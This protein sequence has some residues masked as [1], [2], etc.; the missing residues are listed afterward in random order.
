MYVSADVMQELDILQNKIDCAVN[1]LLHIHD[2]LQTGSYVAEDYAPGVFF[3]YCEMY[4]YS[5]TLR[6]YVDQIFEQARGERLKEGEAMSKESD[7]LPE[8]FIEMIRTDPEARKT[9]EEFVH[10]IAAERVV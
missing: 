9:A 1:C 2:S 3:I 5:D 8:E 10:R 4:D 6:K 7:G